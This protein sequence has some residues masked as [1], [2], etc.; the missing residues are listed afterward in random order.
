MPQENAQE[1]SD[2]KPVAAPGSRV[3]MAPGVQLTPRQ[4]ALLDQSVPADRDILVKQEFRSGYSGAIV[5]L[6]SVGAGRAPLVIKL[7][8]PHELQREYEAYEE[9]VRQVSPQNIAHLQGKPL[10]S[11]DGQLGLLQYTF[12]GGESHLPTTSLQ[13]YYESAGAAKTSEVLNRIFR[14]FG[15][16]W[17]ADNRAQSY[18]LDEYYD[19]L[20]PVH[21]QA[22]P[23]DPGAGPDHTV[24]AGESSVLVVTEIEHGQ[25][26]HLIG[27][28]VIK[29]RNE[30]RRLTLLAPPPPNQAAAPL[31]IRVQCQEPTGY[32]PGD[33]VDSLTVTVTAT[34][35]SLLEDAAEEALAGFHAQAKT[36]TLPAEDGDGQADDITLPNPLVW[37]PGQLYGVVE[38]KMSIIHGDLNLQ[39]VL[40]DAPTGFAWLIDFAETRVGPTLLDLQRLEVQVITKLM[41][42]HGDIPLCTIADIMT[43]LHADPPQPAPPQPELQEPYALLVTIRRLA[44]QYLIDDLDWNE[45]YY[46]LVTA[47]IGSLKYDELDNRTRAMCLAAAAAVEDRIGKPL[48]SGHSAPPAASAPAQ[49]EAQ[50]AASIAAEP[51]PTGRRRTLW[52]GIVF[53]LAA[54][55]LAAFFGWQFSRW[56]SM[57]SD[58]PTVTAGQAAAAP[59]EAAIVTEPEDGSGSADP[60]E[61]AAED[62][63]LP[64]PTV[65]ISAA[66][67]ASGAQNTDASESGAAPAVPATEPSETTEATEQ[68]AAQAAGEEPAQHPVAEESVTEAAATAPAVTP[69]AGDI[70]TNEVD[71]A[72]YVF[73]PGGEFTMGSDEGR[74]DEGPAHT[75]EVDPFWLMRTEVTNEQ[76]ARCVEDGAC[77]PPA[78]DDW[79]DPELSD[80]PVTHVTWEQAAA[81]AE[82]AGGRLPTEA[83]WELAARAD[84]GRPYPWGD[85]L[86]TDEL[87]NFNF[88]M[89]SSSPVGSYPEGAGPFGNLD[90]A[91]NVEEWVADRYDAEYYSTSP[92]RNPQGPDEGP[93]RTVRGG[94]YY[95]NG[96]DVRS[97]A[98]E[99]ILPDASFDSV[100]LRV[101]MSVE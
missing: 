20:L 93:L 74:P 76:Y 75:V 64:E 92:S 32:T 81:Y 67:E 70:R 23:S 101:A 33:I 80:H 66:A 13:A 48:A 71:G 12:A 100:G 3:R 82:W 55:L 14:V 59:T 52:A 61:E 36:L 37:L 9:Y 35:M 39:N 21:L 51:A 85:E 88:A 7:A 98:R 53:A 15:R 90:M 8:H 46:G 94:S 24:L 4:I 11:E 41:P 16:H 40:V 19:R 22:E 47:L 38:T 49:P 56:S 43:R 5:V 60:V 18:V 10:I 45:Y 30:G 42:G 27:F 58:P 63:T 31:R 1:R 62:E 73:I 77:N 6:V 54:V 72:D 57:A 2:E 34:R 91:G 50:P 68:P 79:Q 86:P 87:L 25:T 17:W 95:S 65:E 83:E 26:I 69:Q 84:D 78:S 96:M 29:S 89:G 44:R 28:E 97:F 99:K